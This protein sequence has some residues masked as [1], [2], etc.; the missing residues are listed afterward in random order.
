MPVY[1]FVLVRTWIQAHTLY[2]QQHTPVRPGLSRHLPSSRSGPGYTD[3][4]GTER[5]SSACFGNPEPSGPVD[6]SQSG[7]IHLASR[8]EGAHHPKFFLKRQFRLPTG[9]PHLAL[10]DRVQGIP[11]IKA[12]RCLSL[13]ATSRPHIGKAVQILPALTS[14]RICAFVWV[15]TGIRMMPDTLNSL[16]F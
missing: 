11:I 12:L 15:K 2:S 5:S 13:K 8:A 16:L 14:G 7:I 10:P 9:S 3:L 1:A 4:G 6:S